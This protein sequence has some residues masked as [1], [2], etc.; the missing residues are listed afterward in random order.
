MYWTG[1]S[2]LSRT[3]NTRRVN[4][5]SRVMTAK[6]VLE[7]CNRAARHRWDI[8]E[9]LLT[10]KHQGYQYEHAFSLKWRAMKNWHTLMHL[11]H[12]LNTLTLHTRVLMEKM[13][14]LGIR[15][16]LRFLRETWMHPWVERESNSQIHLM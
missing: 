9:T 10:E 15:D 3:V 14:V 12:L 11:G 7:R 2:L 5:S 1:T 8:E 16:T 6:N 13:H 4:D